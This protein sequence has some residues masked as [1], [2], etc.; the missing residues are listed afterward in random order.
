MLRSF[1][2]FQLTLT[3]MSFYD[4]KLRKVAKLRSQLASALKASHA[5]TSH[6]RFKS[7]FART[8]H[9]CGCARTCACANFISQLTDCPFALKA[10]HF[11]NLALHKK[12]VLGSTHL[13][14]TNEFSFFS[15]Y[16]SKTLGSMYL[17][18]SK[19]IWTIKYVLLFS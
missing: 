16:V 8:S 14:C 19:D 18:Q 7:L 17:L 12:L 15:F 9:T 13:K 11:P 4:T 1:N 5:C 10:L 6:A 2:E 3:L